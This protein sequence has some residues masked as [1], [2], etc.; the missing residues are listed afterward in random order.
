MAKSSL[1]TLSPIKVN[2]SAILADLSCREA[3]FIVISSGVSIVS[4]VS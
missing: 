2:P 3:S 4:E 1:E